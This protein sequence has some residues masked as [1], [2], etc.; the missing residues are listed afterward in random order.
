MTIRLLRHDVEIPVELRTVAL[1]RRGRLIAIEG[2][3]RLG[4]QSIR[5]MVGQLATRHT[6]EP[7]QQR[8]TALMVE[9]HDLL[10]RV[11]PPVTAAPQKEA[12]NV[13]RLGE[14]ALDTDRLVVF[15]SGK[16]VALTPREVMLLKHLLERPG[17][18]VTR[19][20]LLSDVWHYAYDGDDRTVDVHVSRLRTKLP[21]LKGRLLAIRGIGYRLVEDDADA[22]IANC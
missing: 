1:V 12:S 11:L 17:R 7:V 21:S 22:R 4:A 15:E 5:E 16:A 6:S 3:A 14:L 2:M 10:H 9:V 20:Q 13:L 18:V 19:T 8:L